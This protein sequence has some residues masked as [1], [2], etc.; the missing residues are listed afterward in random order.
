MYQLVENICLIAAVLLIPPLCLLTFLLCLFRKDH[1]QVALMALLL[2]LTGVGHF[3]A[4]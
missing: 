1:R 3:F 4:V 2:L